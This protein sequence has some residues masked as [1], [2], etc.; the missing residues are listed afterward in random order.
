ML[1]IMELVILTFLLAHQI[2]CT[3]L[4]M[5]IVQV[6]NG[7]SGSM[8][9]ADDDRST[10]NRLGYHEQRKGRQLTDTIAARPP[11]ILYQ[12]GVS[13]NSIHSLLPHSFRFNLGSRQNP[14]AIAA[15]IIRIVSFFL[16]APCQLFS[17]FVYVRCFNVHQCC[18]CRL[19]YL[20][21]ESRSPFA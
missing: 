9:T 2:N 7:R 13:F 17:L 1:S 21:E 15:I 19:K 20:T 5:E 18:H 6:T 14:L 3:R 4:P 12:I 8:Q 10:E 11:R 16:L